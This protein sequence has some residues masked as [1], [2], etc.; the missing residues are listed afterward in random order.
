[1][2]VPKTKIQNRHND[3]MHFMEVRA[4]EVEDSAEMIIE[5]R[6]I[7][8][9]EKT[10][11]FRMGDVDYFEIIDR[12]ALDAADMSDIF[13]KYNHSEEQMVVARSKNGT[14]TVDI[15]DDGAW[16]TIKLANTTTGRDL[17]ELVRRGDIDKMSF[18]FTIDEESYNETEHTWT[19]RKIKKLWEVSAVPFPAYE[20]TT[21]YARRAGEVESRLAEVESFRRK[22]EALYILAKK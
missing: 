4:A 14:L 10:K 6:A 7:V 15:R 17:Y 19:V 1:M 18:G 16:V 5:G 11:L 21:L 8:F 2:P 22:A 12:G 3:Y 13:V 9:N 20:A